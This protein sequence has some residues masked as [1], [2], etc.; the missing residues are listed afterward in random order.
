MDGILTAGKDRFPFLDE[1]LHPFFLII[2]AETL[3][4]ALNL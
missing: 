3:G 1:G 2:R 4:T